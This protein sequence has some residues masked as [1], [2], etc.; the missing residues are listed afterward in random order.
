MTE[1][2]PLQTT[3]PQLTTEFWVIYKKPLPQVSDKH[4]KSCGSQRGIL[5]LDSA[6]LF[7]PFLPSLSF[8]Y[9]LF[10]GFLC[11]A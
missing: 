1:Y 3:N 8:L 6:V 2:A 4:P 9:F 5:T 10:S 11:V 7:F